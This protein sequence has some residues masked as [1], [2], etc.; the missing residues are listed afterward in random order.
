[1]YGREGLT[2]EGLGSMLCK[3]SQGPHDGLLHNNQLVTTCF[4]GELFK[5]EVFDSSDTKHTNN[6]Y[7]WP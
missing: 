2:C 6:L 1:M 3:A 5:G 7:V 4:M